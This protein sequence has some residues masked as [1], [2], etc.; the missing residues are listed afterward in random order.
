ML[1]RFFAPSS[2]KAQITPL[3]ESL[4]I[5]LAGEEHNVRVRRSAKAKRYTLRL[6]PATRELV[7][8]MPL[9][10]SMVAMKDFLA[11]HEGWVAARLKDL[12]QKIAFIHGATLP[13]RGEPHRIEHQ[14]GKRGT[15]WLDK[16]AAGAPVIAVAGDIAHLPRRVADFLKQSAKRELEAVTLKHAARLGVTIRRISIKDTSSR[17]GSCSA[18]GSL[19]YSWRII[20]AP[21]LVLDY[22]AA[23][24]VCHRREM[25]HSK[26]FWDL[27][28]EIFP[29]TDA[30][31]AWL[32]KQGSLL[33]RYG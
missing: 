10:G 14:A 33:H 27:V 25:N 15:V 19:S 26:R 24:E 6:K 28:Y 22:L 11:R 31:E 7:L 12:P 30:A 32:K 16:D 29:E 18:Q 4:Q 5:R 1:R 13:F 9:R 3:S 20:L 17:W 21:P 2:T 8:T 23:H